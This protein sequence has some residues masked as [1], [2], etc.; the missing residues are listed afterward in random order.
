MRKQLLTFLALFC[1]ASFALAQEKKPITWQDIPTWKYM[2]S[3]SFQVSPDGKWIAYGNVAL[4]ADGE[5]I[6]QNISDPSAEKKHSPSAQQTSPRFLLVM[7]GNGL[8]LKFT[9]RS[10]KAKQTRERKANR[11]ETNLL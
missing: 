5:V 10:L 4:E 1:F 7:T 3:N 9:L 2:Q 6:L 8:P 11:F